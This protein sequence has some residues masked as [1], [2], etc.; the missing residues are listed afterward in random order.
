L[1]EREWLASSD[2]DAMFRRVQQSGLASRRK[3]FLFTAACLHRLKPVLLYSG[4]REG[5]E[6]L[7]RSADGSVTD[8]ERVAVTMAVATAADAA[9]RD[10]EN[11][12]D[13]Y[14]GSVNS[15]AAARDAAIA[16]HASLEDANPDYAAQYVA[17]HA[18][19]AYSLWFQQCKADWW[20]GVPTERRVQASFLRDIFG[21]LPF[22]PLDLFIA[23]QTC[24]VS[25][26]ARGIY[27]ECAFDRLPILADALEDS[28]CNNRDI[29]GHCRGSETHVRGCWVLDVLLGKD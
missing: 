22:R 6:I 3:R 17:H 11:I 18:A 4:L 20:C 8:V 25:S 15:I 21:I 28:G 7:E 24:T 29:L 13:P 26:L 14:S 2:I 16:V 19:N 5:V 12:A 1:T 23:R 9:R 27:D 10:Y